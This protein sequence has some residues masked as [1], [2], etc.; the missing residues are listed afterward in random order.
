MTRRAAIVVFLA[1]VSS[2]CATVDRLARARVPR[3][4]ADGLPAKVFQDPRCPPD[5][6]CG[7]TCAPERW[8]DVITPPK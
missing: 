7:F 1:A 3:R 4:C 6:I 5:G 8:A 2:S